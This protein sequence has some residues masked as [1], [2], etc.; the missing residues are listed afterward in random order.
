[1]ASITHAATAQAGWRDY[2]ELTKPKVVALMIITSAIGMLLASDSAV[3]W[4]TLLFG[5]LGIALCAGSAAAINHVVDRR[6]DVQM[7]R[8]Q[9]RPLAQGRVAP[10]NAVLFAMLL[11]SA[12][13]AVL[14]SWTNTLTAVLTLGSL[15]GYALVYTAFLKRATP[16]NIVIGGLAGA[17]P[18]LLGWTAVSGQIDAGGLLLVL[19]IFAWTPP[20]FWALA[21]HRKAEYAK[22]NI[23]MLPVT[24]GEHYTKLHIL[25]YTFIL[26][27]VSLLP[28]VIHMSGPLYLV[29]A[30]VLGLRFIDW[31]I[32]LLRN[33]RPHAAIKTFKY[34]LWYLLWLFVALLLD[35]YIEVAGW[36]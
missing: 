8:T 23:P 30:V 13:L 34:S 4:S 3:P 2:L 11:G 32:A 5:N 31:A 25:L 24:H 16:Q 33:S 26:L 7:A 12:G 27:A 17:A 28:F 6:I 19:I 35:H 10:L 22:V 15:L 21:I 9:R 20:H 29:A 14:L 18:P 36:L 1:M